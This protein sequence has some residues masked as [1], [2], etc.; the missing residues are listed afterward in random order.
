[1]R[2]GLHLRRLRKAEYVRRF[3]G[4]LQ[5]WVDPSDVSLRTL[6]EMGL[7]DPE[8]EEPVVLELLSDRDELYSVDGVRVW[9]EV[10]IG[11]TRA[12]RAPAEPIVLD[13]PAD[14]AEDGEQPD[15]WR[16][17]PSQEELDEIAG[18]ARVD[19][20]TLLRILPAAVLL[21][22]VMLGP[23][24]SAFN[25]PWQTA[26]WVVVA[27]E[28]AL[29]AVLA[30]LDSADRRRL[31]ADAEFGWVLVVPTTVHASEEDEP[32]PGPVV[33]VLPVTERVWTIDGKPAAWRRETRGRRG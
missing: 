17:R 2:R 8:N 14:W 31:R 9:K 29:M 11:V 7:L 1:M 28:A 6:L 15:L 26:V 24:L 23:L 32:G 30:Y 16:R 27:A 25:V 5:G 22:W 19:W 4:P 21:P 13:V 12:A 20:R 33:E 3:E 10:P 18:Y